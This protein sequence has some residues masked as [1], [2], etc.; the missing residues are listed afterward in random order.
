MP[1]AVGVV[2]GR[3]SSGNRELA[4]PAVAGQDLETRTRTRPLGRMAWEAAAAEL[5][6]T[7]TVEEVME[8]LEWS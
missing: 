2:R 4:A 5:E 8:A 7:A 3:V 1:V 6:A